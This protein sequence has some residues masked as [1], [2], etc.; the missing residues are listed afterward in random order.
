MCKK[1]KCIHAVEGILS[2]AEIA[3]LM[4]FAGLMPEQLM[5]DLERSE[6]ETFG[7][8]VKLDNG[9]WGLR[10][11][12]KTNFIVDRSVSVL[13]S[14]GLP[15]LLFGFA[16]KNHASKP[17]WIMGNGRWFND[18]YFFIEIEEPR[19]KMTLSE[20]EEKLGFKVE[21]VE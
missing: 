3:A 21:I 8:P 7:A 10:I 2:M 18:E 1:I 4:P 6:V 20:V 14:E 5:K 17:F 15:H 19:T 11:S 9:K 12:R 13:N 16:R